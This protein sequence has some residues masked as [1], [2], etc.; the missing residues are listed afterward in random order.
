MEQFFHILTRPD[1]IPIAGMLLLVLFYYWLGISQAVKNDKYGVNRN[2]DK[3]HCWPYLTRIEFL[4]TLLIMVILTVWSITIDAPLEELANPSKTPNPAKAPWYFLGLQEMLV[5]FDP[6]I[7]GV[8]LPT[9]IIIGLMAIPYLDLNPKGTGYYSFRQRRAAILIF[10][11]GYLLWVALII[12]GTFFRGP[13]WYFFYPWEEWDVHR[14]VAIT[15]VDLPYLFGIRS[16]FW[17]SVFG[18]GVVLGYY[19]LGVFFY[20]Y[21]KKKHAE[22]MKNLGLLRYVIIAFLF[23]TMTALPM[24]MFLRIFFNIKYVWVTPWFNI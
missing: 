5:Y 3:V 7:A 20:L 2:I 6:W 9:F 10:S 14:I 11:F 1:N 19:S 15:N 4:A 21:L 18:G 23:L 16:Y 8:V 12:I 13:G 17:S 24:K 22:L